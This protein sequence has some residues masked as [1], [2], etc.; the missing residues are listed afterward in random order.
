M[1]NGVVFRDVITDEELVERNRKAALEK[2][3]RKFI[4]AEGEDATKVNK[5]KSL[6]ERSDV[7]SFNGYTTLVPKRS[8]IHIPDGYQ[9]RINNHKKGSKLV[10]WLEFL[11]LNRG[12]VS[13][14]ELTFAQA[15]GEEEIPPNLKESFQTGGNLVVAVF[16]AGP[17]TV[18][19]PKSEASEPSE[20]ETP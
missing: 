15:K 4:P 5:V 18:A 6:L 19:P 12:W 1:R 16:Q 17:I 10:G 9:Q 14:V 20:T 8:I 11:R 2:Q 7:I 13:T 3:N